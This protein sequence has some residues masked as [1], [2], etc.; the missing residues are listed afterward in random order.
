MN[1]QIKNYY[2]VLEVSINA[3]GEE[4]YQAYTRAKNAYSGDSLALYSLLSHDEA[5]KI[6]ELI[7]EAYNILSD[8]EK[9]KQYN[10]VRGISADSVNLSPGM[11]ADKVEEFKQNKNSGEIN[12]IV[13]KKR[14]G[15]EFTENSEFEKEIEQCEEFTGEF[16]KRVREYKNV[17][18]QRLAEM[19][20]I[21]KTYLQYIEDEDV[22]KMPATVYIRGFVYQ[23]AKCLKLNPE[24]VANSFLNRI[25]KLKESL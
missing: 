18:I 1:E 17:D 14:Y 11:S 15:L 3:N 22:A 21:S 25:K 5:T 6:L 23:Y 9:R 8:P 20:K 2:E 13:A 19:T 10:N 12:K 24:L 16:L 4:I 7:E